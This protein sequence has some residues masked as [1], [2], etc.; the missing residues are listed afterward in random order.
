MAYI[1]GV[2]CVHVHVI[3]FWRDVCMFVCRCYVCCVLCVVFNV[4]CCHTLSACCVCLWLCMSVIMQVVV[5]HCVCVGV[6]YISVGCEVFVCLF[7][8][9]CVFL[10]M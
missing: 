3:C 9:V 2:L 10:F 7:V 8:S 1:H 6:V 5:S 4:G